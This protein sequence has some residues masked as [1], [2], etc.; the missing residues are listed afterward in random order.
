[1]LAGL[2]DQSI[3]RIAELAAD[4]RHFDR[5]EVARI[6]D[7]W[8][9]NTRPLFR[10][11]LTR[12]D[13]LRERRARAALAWM[14][15]LALSRREWMIEIAGPEM[16]SL[17]GKAAEEPAH[18]RDYRGLVLPALTPLDEI[19]LGR[20][21][22]LDRAEVGMLRVERAGGDLSGFVELSAPRRYAAPDSPQTPAVHLYLD[23]VD[24]VRFDSDDRSG[25]PLM[26]GPD[27]RI[28]A[29]GR[30]RAK[31]ATVYV[32]DWSWHLSHAGR[33][34]DATTARTRRRGPRQPTRPP[35]GVARQAAFAVYRA[36]VAIRAVRFP[37]V[38]GRI[39]VRELCAALAG[40]GSDVLAAAGAP[41]RDAAFRGL[42]EKWTTRSP[43]LA[44]ELN[45]SRPRVK[46]AFTGPPDF[47]Q[48]TLVGW[49][50]AATINLAAPSDDSTWRLRSEQFPEV[51]R[52]TL[53]TSAFAAPHTFARTPPGTLT[54]AD[55][56]LTIH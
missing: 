14:A 7:V 55:G 18:H 5:R 42:V 22:D 32:E 28:G 2:L 1:M 39:P 43:Y 37:H 19:D 24:L 35:L 16:R 29:R 46:P 23:G 34:A 54:V 6:A 51:A 8:D 21:Y 49:H 40:A 10:A 33:A 3:T 53:D 56:A 45:D 26:T 47:A 13:W 17:L 20:D 44:A 38:V 12:P 30:L 11:A 27:I 15:G 48:L 41:E 4:G 31:A 9:N 52:L 50:T 25:V 36:M